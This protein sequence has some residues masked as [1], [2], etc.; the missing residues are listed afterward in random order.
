MS[1]L[2]PS[3]QLQDQN[4]RSRLQYQRKNEAAI[5]LLQKQELNFNQ[6]TQQMNQHDNITLENTK[7]IRSISKKEPPKQ[8][9]GNKFAILIPFVFHVIT[10]RHK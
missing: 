9:A 4:E 8:V 5:Q 7:M 3:E 1:E 10:E 2:F 6:L